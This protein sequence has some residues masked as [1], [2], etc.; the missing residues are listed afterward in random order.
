[1]FDVPFSRKFAS[2]SNP[3]PV[4][5]DTWF[6]Q[7]AQDIGEDPEHVIAATHGKRAVD[8]LSYFKPHLKEHDIDDKVT[9]FE[10]SILFFADARRLHGPGSTFRDQSG[11]RWQTPIV[12]TPI[13]FGHR[14][15]NPFNFS[16]HL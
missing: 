13:P 3:E 10:E 2:S 4:K 7:V 12:G 9:R 16:V 14:L 1:M 5:R 15:P 6:S 11:A 8:N